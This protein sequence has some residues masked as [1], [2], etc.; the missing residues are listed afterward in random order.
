MS[1]PDE[2]LQERTRRVQLILAAIAENPALN[3]SLREP[4]EETVERLNDA[5]VEGV[6]EPPA[7]N[8]L[9]DEEPIDPPE[10]D[11]PRP[12]DELFADDSN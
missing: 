10:T 1:D 4:T 12:L 6:E 8:K 9:F 3:E 5:L 7:P 2:S 11:G